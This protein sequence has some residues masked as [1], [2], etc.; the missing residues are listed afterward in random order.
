MAKPVK[1]KGI[2]RVD[3]MT[4]VLAAKLAT[5]KLELFRVEKKTPTP[6]EYQQKHAET[7][8]EI[9]ESKIIKPVSNDLSSPAFAR[10]FIDLIKR[11]THEDDYRDL[12]V[13]IN[14][15]SQSKTGGIKR[16]KKSGKPVMTWESYDDGKDY[17]AF[18]KK[19]DAKEV[20][21]KL[22]KAA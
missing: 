19:I 10:D 22:A 1:A 5:K 9:L 6:Q 17:A 20:A 7:V 18:F 16:N 14:V 12:R 13:M 11:T 21:E 3:G 15:P 4:K 2:F 8:A